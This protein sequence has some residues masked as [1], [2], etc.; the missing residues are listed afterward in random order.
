MRLTDMAPGMRLAKDVYD[1][2]G[3][4]LMRSGTVVTERLVKALRSWGIDEVTIEA[5]AEDAASAMLDPKTAAE[6]RALLD[7][8]FSLSNRDHPVIQALYGLCLE[9]ALGNR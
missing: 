9:R 6:I 1:P 2:N 8:Q 3:N 5:D 4:V 7:Q